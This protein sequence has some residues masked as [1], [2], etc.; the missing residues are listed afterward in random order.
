MV[1]PMLAKRT[2]QFLPAQLLSPLAQFLSI[3]IWTHI[4]SATT[5]GV[6]TLLATQQELIRVI[7]IGWWSHY[8][9]RFI[10]D[11]DQNKQELLSANRTILLISSLL[12]ILAVCFVVG[13]FFSEQVSLSLVISTVA[14]V[15]FRNINSHNMAIKSVEE[16]IFQYNF[17]ALSGPVLGLGIGIIF[18]VYYGDSPVWP[19][20]GYAIGELFGFLVIFVIERPQVYTFK[21]NPAILKDAKRYSLPLLTASFFGWLSVNVVRFIIEH[22]LGIDVVGAFSVGFGLGQRAASLA[23]MLVTAASL[24]LA[25]RIM[26]EC[27]LQKA[28]QQ[29]SNNF[30]LLMGVMFPALVGMY[31]VNDLLVK[32]L[33]AEEF[34]GVTLDVLPWAILSG[35]IFAVLYNYVNHYFIIADKTKFI[36]YGD[37]ITAI[38]VCVSS[39]PLID[40]FGVKGGV[41]AMCLS[42]FSVLVFLTVYLLKYTQFIFPFKSF[43]YTVFSVFI[44]Y[45]SVKY[46]RDIFE[47]LLYKLISS[48]VV[49]IFVYSILTAC[50]YRAQ[51]VGFFDR[52]LHRKG[53]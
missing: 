21:I 49:G 35:G 37:A 4:S 8:L 6:V 42:S 9:L 26:Q 30:V 19:I 10:T 46:T 40:Y 34:W 25:I 38:L 23:S 36:V 5:I 47:S 7:F 31:S 14:F 24:P 16:K 32:L 52:V 17:L 43:L 50:N 39:F 13:Y 53:G 3:I 27:G 33:V 12:Q 48:I 51:L 2:L 28:M 18:L 44:M 11:K 41:I 22:K 45:L 20:L 15:I 1:T 29:L